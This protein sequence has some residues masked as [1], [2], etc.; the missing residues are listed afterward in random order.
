MRQSRPAPAEWDGTDR[1]LRDLPFGA[2]LQRRGRLLAGYRDA[3]F[4]A[5][6]DTHRT[7]VWH[8][9]VISRRLAVG[10]GATGVGAA[11]DPVRIMLGGLGYVAAAAVEALGPLPAARLPAAVAGRGRPGRS[12]GGG[13]VTAKDRRRP[14]AVAIM[15]SLLYLAGVVC[16]VAGTA[17]EH[18]M[19]GPRVTVVV[20]SL[21]LIGAGVYTFAAFP[22]RKR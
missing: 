11:C 7:K 13:R 19:D 10:G 5:R 12:Y 3:S 2:P 16:V 6:P 22:G 1:A 17:A 9:A 20:G 18:G 8:V 21:L 15:L 4:L 14:A